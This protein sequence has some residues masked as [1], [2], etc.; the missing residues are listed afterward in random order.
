MSSNS[1]SVSQST[2]YTYNINTVERNHIDKHIH[3]EIIVDKTVH[4][5]NNVQQH[6]LN[7]AR[8]R[9]DIFV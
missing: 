7:V 8:Q 3:N 4:V 1:I 6:E 9:I 5:V 2:S